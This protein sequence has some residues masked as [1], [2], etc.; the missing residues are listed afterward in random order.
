MK[1][2]LPPLPYA[3]SALEPHI[4]AHT[5]SLH[6]DKHHAGYVD[7]L[8]LAL[9]K[10]PDSLQGKSAYWLV[11]NL[12]KVPE[13]IRDTVG[14]N[15]GGH[16]N[17]SLFWHSM[18]PGAGV[19]PNSALGAAIDKNFGSVAKFKA[20][21]EV[22]GNEVFGSGWVWLVKAPNGD[23]TLKIVTTS[24]HDNPITEGFY[25]LLVNDVWEHAYY[26]QHENRRADYLK[27]WWSVANWK[28]A[29]RRFTRAGHNGESL[30]ELGEGAVLEVS[31]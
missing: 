27:D 11:M 9:E 1:H 2:L 5:M 14:N 17:H 20:A 23:D 15:A 18:A 10:A 4:G 25:P 7:A 24:G 13:S 29:N 12:D 6:H 3:V 31:N 26:L 19:K 28:E 16:L 22:A 21:F 8:N 30:S